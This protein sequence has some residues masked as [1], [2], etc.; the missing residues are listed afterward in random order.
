MMMIVY[1]MAPRPVWKGERMHSMKMSEAAP[2][3]CAKCISCLPNV[4]RTIPNMNSEITAKKLRFFRK[5]VA[6]NM[7]EI[8]AKNQ[9]GPAPVS[10]L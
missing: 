6:L 10:S 5:K 9:S 2:I 7:K 1:M 4:L 8:M 3:A